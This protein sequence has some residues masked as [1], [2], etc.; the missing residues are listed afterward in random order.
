MELKVD[1]SLKGGVVVQGSST[2]EPCSDNVVVKVRLKRNELLDELVG[3]TDELSI[4]NFNT[5]D[6]GGGE[7]T[8]DALLRGGHNGAGSSQG[9]NNSGG[10]L[11]FEGLRLLAEQ[12]ITERKE[13]LMYL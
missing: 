3:V 9:R 6:G 4:D 7:L 2:E 8:T 10:E 1:L 5:S 12:G 13:W 11:H